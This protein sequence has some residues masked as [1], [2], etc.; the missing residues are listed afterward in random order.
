MHTKVANEFA[1]A[2][3]R[4]M[5]LGPRQAGAI[6]KMLDEGTPIPYI[7]RYR[8]EQS[9]SIDEATLEAVK[10]RLKSLVV[11]DEQRKAIFEELGLSEDSDE[12]IVTSILAAEDMN[13]LSDLYVQYK[14]IQKSDPFNAGAL[15]ILSDQPSS[16]TIQ[17]IV[18]PL[19]GVTDQYEGQI[20][21]TRGFQCD[22]VRGLRGESLKA[23]KYLLRA[24][25]G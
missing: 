18:E 24:L 9:G 6:V 23:A 17:E 10:K 2:I 25:A 11:L 4:E 14:S 12:S 3:S 7:A 19:A 13:E 5:N 1:S 22:S 8:K 20:R 21:S 15:K 16:V